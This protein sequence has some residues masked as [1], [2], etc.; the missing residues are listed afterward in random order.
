MSN[1]EQILP[2]FARY[3]EGQF[4]EDLSEEEMDEVH[5]GYRLAH[6]TRPK[7]DE[8]F[9]TLKYPSDNEEGG[10]FATKKYPSDTDE[11][12]VTLKYPSDGDDDVIAIETVDA[13][14][15]TAIE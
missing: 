14:D 6:P 10:D 5:G 7:K 9:T 2:F 11:Y 3:L 12:A 1:N 4:C 8:I 13:V 15:T